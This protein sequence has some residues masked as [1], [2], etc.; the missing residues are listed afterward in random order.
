MRGF[1]FFLIEATFGAGL[2]R[3]RGGCVSIDVFKGAHLL[4]TR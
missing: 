1:A 4:N 2:V 3:A